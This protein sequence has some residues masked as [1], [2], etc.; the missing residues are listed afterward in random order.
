MD[1]SNAHVVSLAVLTVSTGIA[2]AVDLKHRRIPNVLSLATAVTG[3]ALAAAGITGIT[4]ASSLVGLVL[5]VALML[6]GHLFGATG[7]GDV[8]LFAAAGTVLGASHTFKAFLFVAIAGGVLAVAIAV[9]RGR[10]KHTVTRTAALCG[11]S[12]SARGEI[13]SPAANNRFAYG[14]AIAVGCIVAALL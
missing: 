1:A 8:K 11:R 10:L 14:P 2:T 7:A 4:L 9:R 12:S 3:L 13:E 6:P 5:G